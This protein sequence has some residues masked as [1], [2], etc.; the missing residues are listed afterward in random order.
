MVTRVEE[1]SRFDSRG[2]SE[3][4]VLRPDQKLLTKALVFEGEINVDP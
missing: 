1:P 4:A 2:Y 3:E